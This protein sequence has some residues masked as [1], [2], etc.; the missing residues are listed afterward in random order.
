MPVPTSRAPTPSRNHTLTLAQCYCST[1]AL[2]A[3]C[4]QRA[5]VREPQPATVVPSLAARIAAVPRLHLHCCSTPV[6][7]AL[8]LHPQLLRLRHYSATSPR[9][10]CPRLLLLP[11]GLRPC[12]F[13]R[14]SCW[15]PPAARCH[16]P[17]P[18]PPHAPPLSCA[19][20]E[21]PLAAP[22]PARPLGAWPCRA[23]AATCSALL[24]QP[25][26]A[27]V[28]RQAQRPAAARLRAA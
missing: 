7:P 19:R 24:V 9:Q 11:P 10:R 17:D 5:F 3:V 20:A 13:A 21:P 8:Y 12:A 2:R 15:A 26:P 25:P 1:S 23:R 28:R 27:H 22:G 6:P 14:L 4:R 16:A 18:A